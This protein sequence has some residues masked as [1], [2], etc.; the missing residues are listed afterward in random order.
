M[1]AMAKALHRVHQL[2]SLLRNRALE[3]G[4]KSQGG[5]S[6]SHDLQEWLGRSRGL[7][8]GM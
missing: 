1:T 6:M 8:I 7:N 2:E 4:L 3:L 5:A